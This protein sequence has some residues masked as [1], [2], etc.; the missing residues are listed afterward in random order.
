MGFTKY[1]RIRV[2]RLKLNDKV[3]FV[4][5]LDYPSFFATPCGPLCSDVENR[6]FLVRV[7]A[8]SL[9]CGT[10]VVS[11]DVGACR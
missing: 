6:I 8:E 9:V 11:F 10:P 3:L 2:E 4:G 1:W 7:I 5:I